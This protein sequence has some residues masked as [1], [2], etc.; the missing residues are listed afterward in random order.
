[1]SPLANAI[2]KLLVRR[3]RGGHVHVTYG[4]L[5]AALPDKL[6]TH[7]RS[8]KLHAA[9]DEVSAACRAYDLPCVPAIVWRAGDGKPGPAYFRC[10]HARQRTDASRRTAWLEEHAAVLRAIERYPERLTV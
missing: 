5:S 1:M 8:R 2:Y 10:V 3:L 4:E 7:R 6:A 9:L